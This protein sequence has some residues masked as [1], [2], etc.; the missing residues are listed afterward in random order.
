MIGAVTR[1]AQGL[2]GGQVLRLGNEDRIEYDLMRARLILVGGIDTDIRQEIVARLLL[3]PGEYRRIEPERP[4]RDVVRA[5]LP[6]QRQ[7][8]IG[9]K[10]IDLLLAVGLTFP[11]NLDTIFR[12]SYGK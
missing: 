11:P 5:P 4:Q 3:A 12:L 6:L 10:P 2:A 8:P 1:I 9:G 7:P